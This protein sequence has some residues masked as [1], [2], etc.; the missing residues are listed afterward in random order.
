MRRGRSGRLPGLLLAGLAALVGLAWAGYPWAGAEDCVETTPA[1]ESMAWRTLVIRVPERVTEIE[2]SVRTASDSTQRAA[3]MQKLCP[4]AVIANPMLFVFPEPQRAS[5]HM[6][7]VHVPLDILFIRA[8]GVISEIHRMNPGA[9]LTAPA[10]PIRYALELS[11]GQ[12]EEL[13]LA[14]GHRV[15]MD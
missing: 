4:D 6:R 7:N 13:G 14:V 2:L 11:A 1:L 9:T 5:F 3:G 10:S 12:A 15:L 8:D